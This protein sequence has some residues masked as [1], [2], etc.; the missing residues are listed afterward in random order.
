[1]QHLLR[2]IGTDEEPLTKVELL[3]F[4]RPATSYDELES[5]LTAAETVIQR[6][7]LRYRVMKLCTG[8]LSFAASKC[9]DIEL[10]APGIQRWMEASSCSNFEDFQARRAMIRFRDADKKVKFVHTL[11]GSGVALPRVVVAILETFQ[12]EDGSVIVPE[13]LRPYMHGLEK[14]E[15]M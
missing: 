7:G 2:A 14:I 15:K 12:Q 11:N 5:L 10:W 9:Y 1:M 6:L 13:V 3:K 8:E 4:V